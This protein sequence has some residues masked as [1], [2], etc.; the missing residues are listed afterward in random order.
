MSISRRSFVERVGATGA[1]ALGAF[2]AGGRGVGAFLAQPRTVTGVADVISQVRLRG[3]DGLWNVGIQ[4]GRIAQITQAAIVGENVIFGDGR[5]LTEGLV[6]HHIHLDKVLTYERFKWD[7][8]SMEA[9]RQ[10]WEKERAEGKLLRGLLVWRENQV[11]ATYTADDVYARAIQIAKIESAN[12]TTAMRTHCV[13]DGV[14]GVMSLQGLLR[15]RQAIKPYMDLQISVHPQDGLLLREA[16][17][18]DLIR[19][20]LR[21]GADGLGGI[22]EVET[23]RT[24]DYLDLVFKL[25]KDHGKFV[26]VHAD[27]ARDQ[28]FSPPIMVAKTR[29]YK[30]Q[31]QVT[32]SHGFS[33]GFQPRERI[34]P[35]FDEMKA[36]GVSLACAPTT[37]LEERITIPRSKGVNVSIMTD[38]VGDPWNRGVRADLIEQANLYRRISRT[39]SSNEA[40]EGVFDMITTCPATSLGLKDHG[41]RVGAKADLVL[42][43]AE[44]APQAIVDETPRAMV[45]KEGRVVA[46][47]GRALW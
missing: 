6:E 17:E 19:R 39:P 44:S 14:R 33:L 1:A 35:L 40:L 26:D 42:F 30:M 43:N 4:D 28:T 21:M 45:F 23:T 5:L 24:D 29:K 31:G 47:S 15:L 7:A 9:E 13:V 32:V 8:V 25:A 18:A 34:L 20:A 37:V 3:R 11:R 46:Q 38:N 16:G 27:Q 22:P 10:Q 41:M 12:G 36:E 2:V